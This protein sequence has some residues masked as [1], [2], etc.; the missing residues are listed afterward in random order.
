MIY[1][2]QKGDMNLDSSSVGMTK[3]LRRH[4]QKGVLKVLK[5][6]LCCYL[7]IFFVTPDTFFVTPTKEGS[8]TPRTIRRIRF[9]LRR[10]DKEA[11]LVLNF[12]V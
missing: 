4:D 5:H 6:Y 7:D 10:H 9:L 12:I 2:E 1:K 3:G 8:T 11:S